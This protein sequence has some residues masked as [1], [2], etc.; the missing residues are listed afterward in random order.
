MATKAEK[1]IKKFRFQIF[2]HIEPYL[3]P[4]EIALYY[5]DEAQKTF[6]RDVIPIIDAKTPELTE[7]KLDAEQAEFEY[8][9]RIL[10]IREARV[11]STD[12]ILNIATMDEFLG[13]TYEVD[14]AYDRV[15]YNTSRFLE[16]VGEPNTLLVDYDTNIVRV[17][18]KP[19]AE[20]TIFMRVERKSNDV[21][22][23]QDQVDVAEDYH[24]VIIDHML[25]LAYSAQDSEIFDMDKADNAERRYEIGAQKARVSHRK[26]NSRAG[27]IRYGGL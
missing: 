4:E 3:I 22:D 13:R 24:R 25:F 16:E 19:R 9:P 1:L 5:L 8:D 27:Q 11:G 15:T 21:N 10:R 7:I 14:A 26:R 17:V 18:P 20:E 2:D 12:R 23:C 6:C